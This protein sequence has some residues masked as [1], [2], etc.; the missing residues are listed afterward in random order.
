MT[1]IE[2]ELTETFRA[3]TAR[4]V[5]SDD[6]YE[7][8]ARAIAAEDERRRRNL[9]IVVGAIAVFGA[10]GALVLSVLEEGS[11]H[12]RWY[13]L[14]LMANLV[15]LATAVGLG[16]LIKRFGKSYAGD[17]FRAN[18]RTGKSYLAL[19][20]VAY[21]LI[22]LS[23]IMFTMSFERHSDWT[24]NA[25]AEQIKVEVSRL[26][27]ILLIIGL[28]HAANI[29]FL[30][31]IGRLLTMNKQL[32]DSIEGPRAV[33]RAPG[34]SEGTGPAPGGGAWILR[35]EPAPGSPPIVGPDADDES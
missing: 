23:F 20:D 5:E 16:P 34:G 2:R 26:G 28:L 30:P 17:V 32:D 11:L 14:E 15:L 21:Y 24:F 12:M 13:I 4:T 22:F 1:A 27:G 9:H 8:V 31:V 10:L 7:R 33:S 3:A 19:T 29:V 35:I 25:G 18:P 6:L